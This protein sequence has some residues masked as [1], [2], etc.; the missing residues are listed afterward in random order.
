MQRTFLSVSEYAPVT[1]S[2]VSKSRMV[3]HLRQHQAM[4]RS[5]LALDDGDTRAALA[6]A[7][8]AYRQQRSLRCGARIVLLRLSPTIARSI[9]R[10]RN[11]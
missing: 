2:Q 8:D 9:H 4:R 6:F 5:R 1:E 3:R 11:R 7:G 10:M